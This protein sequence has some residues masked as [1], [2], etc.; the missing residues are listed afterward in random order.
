MTFHLRKLTPWLAVATTAAFLAPVD[1]ADA[2]PSER[3]IV[4]SRVSATKGWQDTGF[5]V[6][7]GDTYTVSYLSGSWTVDHR[8]FP[9]VG[10]GGYAP[11]VDNQIYQGCK[12]NDHIPYGTLYLRER[13]DDATTLP[14]AQ[15]GILHASQA[16]SVYLRINDDDRCLVDNAGSIR[17]K[18]LKGISATALTDPFHHESDIGSAPY[19]V[20]QGYHNA[21]GR[22][23][24]RT[25]PDHCQ[26]Q[27]FAV[28]LKPTEGTATSPNIYSPAPG[29]VRWQEKKTGCLGMDLADSTNLTICHMSSFNVARGASVQRDEL[30]GI[31]RTPWVHLSIDDRRAGKLPVPLTAAASG[32]DH[33]LDGASLTPGHMDGTNGVETVQWGGH[34]YRVRHEEWVGL[35]EP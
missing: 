11:S 15:G 14:V 30:L 28:D 29:T 34:S 22:C 20:I 9:R 17:I 13:T 6:E 19:H 5:K 2:A 1:S 3:P 31:R 32:W 8:S 12:L 18:L 35:E 10:A 16:G 23:E 33:T 4:V 21:Q 26:N 24:I 7:E 25:G 27:L